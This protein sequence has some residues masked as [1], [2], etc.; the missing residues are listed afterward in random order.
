MRNTRII[1][2]RRNRPWRGDLKG[3]RDPD[4]GFVDK[5]SVRVG[6]T[7]AKCYRCAHA[8]KT[9]THPCETSSA[10]RL[11]TGGGC[12]RRSCSVESGKVLG[13][14]NFGVCELRRPDK[15]VT[16]DQRV[17]NRSLASREHVPEDTGIARPARS[18]TGDA[19]RFRRSSGAARRPRT[20]APS[21]IAPCSGRYRVATP[22][23]NS[24]SERCL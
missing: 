6:L 5:N 8:K 7:S 3:D 13:R 16:D 19:E 12:H 11:A 22:E 18:L 17:R 24:L 20:T 1:D 21:S 15:Q 9:G 4:V 23:Q 2:K 14:G 10:H